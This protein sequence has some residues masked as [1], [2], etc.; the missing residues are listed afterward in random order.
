MPLSARTL[1]FATRSFRRERF[2]FPGRIGPGRMLLAIF[3]ASAAMASLPPPVGRIVV[4]PLPALPMT[5][6]RFPE[7][8][9]T[10]T[11]W[12]TGMTRGADADT[13]QAAFENIH[14]HAWGLWTALTMETAQR[15]EGQP[16]RV[17]ETWL[18]PEE[19]V[20]HADLPNAAAVA[21]W[22]R[23]R[24][25]LRQLGQFRLRATRAA[26]AGLTAGDGAI[27]RIAGFIKFDP[28]AADHILAQGL[29]RVATLDALLQGGAQQIPPFPSA[30][31]AAKPVFQILRRQDL[32]DGRYYALKAWSGPP[33]QPQ[34]WPP[35]L[36]PGAVWIDLLDGGEGSG[37]IDEH[38][39]ADGSTRT[40][41]TTYPLA[42][43]IHYRLSAADAATLD[44]EKPGTDAG[45]GDY[46]VLVAMHISSR[47]IA[48]WTWQT[49]WWTPAPAE[50]PAPSSPAIAALRPPQL[51]G[52][53]QHYAMVLAYTMLSPDQPYVAGENTGAAVYAYNPW[54]EAAFAPE[55]LPDSRAGL[56]PAGRPAPNNVGVETNCMSCHAQA[57]YDP[58]PL[59]PA[60]RF[61][62]A[63]YVDLDDAQFIGTLQL[64]FLWS[65]ARRAK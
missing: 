24:A 16:L 61:T 42:S 10:L 41:A 7:S 40:D 33:A 53:A 29:L 1:A 57:T 62:G 18:T 14:R 22:P 11:R 2:A 19:L 43:L 8:E 28:T 26:S 38:P 44:D 21:Q 37:A 64:D 20:A 60:P 56:D 31:L 58:N 35:A 5:G 12:I 3:S 6:F 4:E 46:A 47:E 63:R 45:A 52:A 27:D 13:V 32:V 25:A 51:R 34:A 30:A 48:R 49:F 59:T 15:S 39:Q 65:I 17:F 50:P 36:W 55:D 54:I 9:A 23:R